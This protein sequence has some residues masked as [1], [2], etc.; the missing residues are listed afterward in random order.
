MEGIE[1]EPSPR[2]VA[3]EKVRALI[4]EID[5]NFSVEISRRMVRRYA[6]GEEHEED[7]YH[8]RDLSN[9]STEWTMDINTEP[10]YLKDK[11]PDVIHGAIVEKQK[12]RK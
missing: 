1:R 2:E 8:F 9:P 10:E 5:P 3:L 6:T 11:L 4:D 12:L 7:V